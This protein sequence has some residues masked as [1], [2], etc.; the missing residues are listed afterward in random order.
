MFHEIPGPAM[1][2]AAIEKFE[3]ERKEGKTSE[4]FCNSG[5]RAALDHYPRFTELAFSWD[6]PQYIKAAQ[7]CVEIIRS[8]NPDVIVNERLCHQGI[9][10]TYSEGRNFIVVSPN[11]FKETLLAVQPRLFGYRKI[12]A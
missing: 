1:L 2:E 8:V 9:D 5:V 6:N 11:T 4:I 7:K 3:R 12:P 10:A